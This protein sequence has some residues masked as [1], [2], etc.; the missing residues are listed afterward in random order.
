MVVVRRVF[1]WRKY[2]G[3]RCVR[4]DDM[5]QPTHDRQRQS[6]WLTLRYGKLLESCSETP[7]QLRGR[8][9][10]TIYAIRDTRIYL[11]DYSFNPAYYR[12]GGD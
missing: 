11:A 3:D 10:N 2:P 8:G 6:P 1:D 5:T 9:Q 7:E 4:D 12:D